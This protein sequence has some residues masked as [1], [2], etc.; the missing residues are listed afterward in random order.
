MSDPI[1]E[2]RGLTCER[3]ERTLFRGMNFAV[4]PGTLVRVAGS[5]G[6]G[7]TTLLR[8]LTGL[9]RPV[10]GEILWRGTP[11]A[12][13]AEDFWSELCYIG[14][15]NGVKDDL[16]VIENVMINARVASLKAT[17]AEALDALAAV[18][19]S[20]FIDVPAGQLSQ[21]QRRRV[22]LARLWLSRS[23]PLWILD[24]PF[25]A[26]DV[27]GVARLATL[28]GE[29]VSEGGVVMLVTHQEVPVEKARLLVIEPETWSPVRRTAV[30][31]ALDDAAADE[32]ENAAR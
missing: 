22:A 19:L 10:E 18:G 32:A 28:I 1:L 20:D 31:R 21:G 26:L 5:N 13:A 16:S 2:V 11:I 6:A 29:H 14:H 9:M 25:T 12:K 4:E 7:K 23:V 15:R 3:G 8:L 24:E 17:E 30:E 27:K